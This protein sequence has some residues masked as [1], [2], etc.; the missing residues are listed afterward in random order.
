MINLLNWDSNLLKRKIG[1]L[2]ISSKSLAYIGLALKK[3]R[4]EKFEYIICKLQKPELSLS[5]H[6]E[7]LGFYLSDIGVT[8]AIQTK[9]FLYS[10]SSEN[11]PPVRAATNG[12]IPA[13]KKIARSLFL[14]SRFYVDPFFTKEDADKL[15]DAWIENSV[16]GEAADIV[17]FIPGK[18]FITCKINEVN[19][20]SIVLIGVKKSYRGKSLGATLIRE[21]MR[22]FQSQNIN[23]VSVR[24]QLRNLNAMNFYNKLGFFIKKYD[25]VFAKNI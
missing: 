25:M 22:W 21:A 4:K 6:M 9:N 7:S 16:V 19:R 14:E 11:C 23:F 12:D 2:K 1:E 13:I 5:M 10:P 18:A 8:W 15:Y 3:A 20:G 17:L 24:T